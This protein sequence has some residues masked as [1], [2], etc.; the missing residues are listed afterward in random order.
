MLTDRP[1]ISYIIRSS[2]GGKWR[3][4]DTGIACREGLRKFCLGH[5]YLTRASWGKVQ[6]FYDGR[7]KLWGSRHVKSSL[8]K[9]VQRPWVEE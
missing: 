6:G 8:D 3:T 5:C 1:L 4:F 2:K 7:T 9:T